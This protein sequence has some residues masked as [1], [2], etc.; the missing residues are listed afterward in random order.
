MGWGGGCAGHQDI[1]YGYLVMA[2]TRAALEIRHWNVTPK[3]EPKHS[4]LIEDFSRNISIKVLLKY[5]QWLG[6]KYHF[7]ILPIIS[8]WKLQAYI[9]TE[10]QLIFIKEN[11][12]SE[13]AYMM[14]ISIKSQLQRAYGF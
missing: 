3:Y 10:L 12:K 8:V 1:P 14:N 7:T 5:L 9:A 6:N 4:W 13:K 2:C 11:T